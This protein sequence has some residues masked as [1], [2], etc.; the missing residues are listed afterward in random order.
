MIHF[1]P[2][3]QCKRKQRYFYQENVKRDKVMYRGIVSINDIESDC[4][5]TLEH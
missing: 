5:L 2:I 4:T 1:V 3:S